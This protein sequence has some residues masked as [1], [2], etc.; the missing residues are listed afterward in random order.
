MQTSPF[1]ARGC[2]SLEFTPKMTVALTGRG[3]TKPG[4]RPGLRVK[5]TQDP[6][7]ANS[8]SVELRLPRRVA[9]DPTDVE[10]VCTP[11]QFEAGS[12]PAGARVGSASARTPLLANRLAGPVHLVAQPGSIP[13]LGVTLQGQLRILLAGDDRPQRGAREEHVRVDPGRADQRVQPQPGRRT[14]AASS[15]RPATSAR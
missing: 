14:G 12:C 3:R 5:L 1:A 13:G 10:D 8:R 7:E 11:E 2:S 6:G 4:R 9:L 15:P